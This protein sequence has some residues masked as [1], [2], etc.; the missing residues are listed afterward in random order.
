MKE[1]GLSLPAPRTPDLDSVYWAYQNA[2]SPDK[3]KV[4]DRTV[5]L[6][7]VSGRGGRC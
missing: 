2:F 1:L 4:S 3:G 7:Q 6:L 5:L